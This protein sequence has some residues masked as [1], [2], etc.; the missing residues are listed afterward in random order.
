MTKKKID[1]L[2]ILHK[3]EINW[4]KWYFLKDKKNPTKSVLEQKIHEAFLKNRLDTA[5]YYVNIKDTTESYIKSSDDVI[6]TAIKEVYVYERMNVIGA[7]Q[8]ILFVTP[9]PAYEK[10]RKWFDGYHQ[11][12][13]SN[14][15][16]IK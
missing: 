14:I 9:T 2:S 16:L 15:Q 13:Y 10:L 6:L 12:T 1:R 11:H 3:R 5:A 8:R 4:L 7:C